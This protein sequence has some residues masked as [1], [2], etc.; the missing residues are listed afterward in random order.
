MFRDLTTPKTPPPIPIRS[1]ITATRMQ[2]LLLRLRFGGR[3]SSCQLESALLEGSELKGDL[4]A[5]LQ[6]LPTVPPSHP[7]C[8]YHSLNSFS[9]ACSAC[10]RPTCLD[11]TAS[12]LVP[13]GRPRCCCHCSSCSYLCPSLTS[14]MM[15]CRQHG[16]VWSALVRLGEG[17]REE[18]ADVEMQW[19]AAPRILRAVIQVFPVSG[20]VCYCSIIRRTTVPDCP[21][22]AEEDEETLLWSRCIRIAFTSNHDER[23]R[24]PPSNRLRQHHVEPHF[25]AIPAI[26]TAASSTSRHLPQHNRATLSPHRLSRPPLHTP[27]LY[28][29]PAI[30][31]AF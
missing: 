15:S 20:W 22:G 27:G 19:E 29:L 4:P 10:A 1:K 17:E 24:R 7:H 23:R 14:Q 26:D 18:A 3:A 31:P 16:G 9:S 12:S 2:Y 5:L 13:P 11:W 25:D 8:H 30:G 21:V 28:L 6:P